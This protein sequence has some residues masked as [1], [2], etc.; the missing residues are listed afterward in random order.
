MKT[1]QGLIVELNRFEKDNVKRSR[2]HMLNQLGHKEYKKMGLSKGDP[3][4]AFEKVN[5]KLRDNPK[6]PNISPRREAENIIKNF[7]DIEPGQKGAGN[8]VDPKTGKVS[9]YDVTKVRH[10]ELRGVSKKKTADIQKLYKG[11]GDKMKS[12][13]YK[14]IGGSQNRRIYQPPFSGTELER[15]ARDL[16]TFPKT[17]LGSPTTTN[18]PKGKIPNPPTI[19][20]PTTFTP[21]KGSVG[22]MRNVYKAKPLYKK[23]LT[24]IKNPKV[25]L[26]VAAVG[27]TIA[28]IQALRKRSMKEDAVAAPINSTGTAVTGTGDDSSTVVVKKKKGEP[29]IIA[30]GCMPGARN[31][32]KGGVELLAKLKKNK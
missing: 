7:Q 12:D 31:R 5:K 2:A 8:R 6:N 9:S 18:I 30:R 27:A 3:L 32:F 1:F 22:A 26:G 24:K 17:K 13:L 14:N 10:N 21:P 4:Q 15:A 25:A 20:P 23:V 16:D 29:T 11:M 19:K 28:G